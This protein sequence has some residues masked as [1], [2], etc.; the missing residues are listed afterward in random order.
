MDQAAGAQVQSYNNNSTSPR[1]SHRSIHI[2]S[3]ITKEIPR[4]GDIWIVHFV[5]SP[6]HFTRFFI[7]R[8]EVLF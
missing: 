6:Y 2:V 8:I 1:T 7:P 4:V 3:N 5:R